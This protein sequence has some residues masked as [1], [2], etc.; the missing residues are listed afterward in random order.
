VGNPIRPYNSKDINDV[1]KFDVPNTKTGMTG[2]SEK[3][4]PEFYLETRTELRDGAILT[5]YEAN[6]SIM[7]DKNGDKMIYEL[8]KSKW[9]LRK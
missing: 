4:V 3:I 9:T 5:K 7:L 6:G 8:K 2:S 1:T